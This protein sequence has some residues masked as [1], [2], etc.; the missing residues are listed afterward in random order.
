MANYELAEAAEADLRGIALYTISKWGSK[1]AARYGAIL[2]AHFEAI[3]NGKTR[4]R[5]FLRHRPELRV[6][7]STTIT[8]STST[9][10][11]NARSSLRCS[12]KAWIS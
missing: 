6:Y 9:G 3:G 11:S 10:K 4:T 2:H 1:Q 7:A 5:I 8:Y 12:M